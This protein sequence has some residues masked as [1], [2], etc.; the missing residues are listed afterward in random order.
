M[1]SFCW[2]PILAPIAAGKPYPIVPKPPEVNICFCSSSAI[3]C[4]VHNWF[5]PTSV[6]ITALVKILLIDCIIIWGVKPMF[7]IASGCFSFQLLICDSQLERCNGRAFFRNMSIAC[8]ASATMGTS[9]ATV[10]E[11]AAASISIWII[12]AS[13]ANSSVFPVIRS[14]NLAPMENKT[15]QWLMAEL[16]A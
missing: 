2:F 13:G 16:A 6:T 14:L 1:T 5:C 10:R 7:F 11:I 15:S 8:F 3:N 9:A 12:V 4:V